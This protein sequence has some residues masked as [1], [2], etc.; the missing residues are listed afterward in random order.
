V[1]SDPGEKQEV[2]ITSFSEDAVLIKEI[3][4]LMLQLY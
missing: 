3:G 1:I 2:D 4:L